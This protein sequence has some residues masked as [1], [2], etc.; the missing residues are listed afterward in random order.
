MRQKRLVRSRRS[1]YNTRRVSTS[2]FLSSE[3]IRMLSVVV[4]VDSCP[5]RIA[6]C[7]VLL[8]CVLAPFR[9]SAATNQPPGREIRLTEVVRRIVENNE[10]IQ[11]KM[12][13]AEISQKTLKA[14]KGIFEPAIVADIDRVDNQRPNNV[15]Q[16]R[17]LLTAELD[18]RN[19]LYN[20]GLEFL[21]PIGSR[22][23]LGVSFRDLQN[24]LQ[25]Q[26]SIL[27]TGGTNIHHEYETFVGV[28]LVQPL[29]KNFG[30]DATTVRIRLAAA[31]S[32]LA[33]QDY[34]RQLMLLV[35]RSESAY[36]DLYLTQEQE[37]IASESI[38]IA[39]AILTDNQNRAKVGRS[40]ELEVLQSEAGLSLRKAR[41]SEAGT[42]RF[43]GVSQLATL[44]SEPTLATNASLRVVDRPAIRELPL[45]YF[46]SYQ[47]AFQL[48]PD[49][50]SRKTQVN[51]E[52]IRLGY[53]RNQ[54]RPQLDLKANYGF[55]GLGQSP[56]DAWDDV[57]HYDFPT[58][59]VGVEMRVPVTGGIRERNEFEA[60]KLGQQRALLGLKEIELQIGNAL[61]SAMYKTRSYLENVQSYEAVVNFHQQLL[62]SQMERLKVGRIDSRTVL[63][64][65]EKL[66]EARIAA[67]ENLIQ[68]QKAFLEMELVTGS[69]LLV[70][71]LDV[72]KPQLQAKTAAFLK[73]RLSDQALE[74]YSRD[75]AKQ[76]YEDLSPNSLTQRKALDRLHR[77]MTDQEVEAQ[78]K[79]V[80]T[81]RQQI[82]QLE[83][84]PPTPGAS[85]SSA[86]PDGQADPAAHR[87]AIELL[88]EKMR[89][90][91]ENVAP[92]NPPRP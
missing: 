7:F 26:G 25:R 44:L 60:A 87:R 66:F 40:S 83:S 56:G 92:K 64:T 3:K 5:R 57:G 17:S 75:A 1:S 36:W 68:Y 59:S 35:A 19:T 48:N 37:R 9:L 32:D 33:F 71:D 86:V 79:A 18:E 34:R 23:K 27:S 65:E 38:T 8:L 21:S 49:Y 42:K 31:A 6:L 14:E 84:N 39:E 89:E 76:Y 41:R 22:F 85:S 78:R 88:R 10:S 12:L 15:Q 61:E 69:T 91:N 30:I 82:Q 43:E 77:E 73:D 51:Q 74:K 47:Q 4:S 11:M 90:P 16:A 62:D 46:E 52:T 80:D 54:R 28:S 55:N 58:W 45:T 29:L 70:R 67:L 24:N 53:A 72:T 81:L 63:E 20:G 50:L 13:E 2:W